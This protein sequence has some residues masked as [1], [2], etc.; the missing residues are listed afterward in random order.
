MRAHLEALATEA[1]AAH[2]TEMDFSELAGLDERMHAVA[3]MSRS[4][5]V[6]RQLIA[7]PRV[8]DAAGAAELTGK[9]KLVAGRALVDFLTVTGI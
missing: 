5:A 3:D 7:L 2:L 9:H 6:H 8:G 1:A 4:R